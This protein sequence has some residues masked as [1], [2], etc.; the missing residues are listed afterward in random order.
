MQ[1]Y[2]QAVTMYHEERSAKD[3]PVVDCLL[4]VTNRHANL[5]NR[6]LAV[7]IIPTTVIVTVSVVV[8]LVVVVTAMVTVRVAKGCRKWVPSDLWPL[9]LLLPNQ[10]KGCL[11]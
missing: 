3:P 5:K 1:I 7:A 4:S 8:L 10:L 9:L 2:S 11:Q 6:I